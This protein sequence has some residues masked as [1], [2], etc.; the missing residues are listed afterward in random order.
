MKTI[1]IAAAVASIVAGAACAQGSPSASTNSVCLDTYL[2]D[3]TTTVNSST[4]LFHMRDGKVWKNSLKAPCPSLKF[5]G[6]KFVTSEDEICSNA[7][8]IS[9]LKTD[10]VCALGR[11]TPYAPQHAGL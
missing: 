10:E 11:F 2:I 7:Q 6:F 8:A 5:Y 4:L 9:V 3:H 1:I